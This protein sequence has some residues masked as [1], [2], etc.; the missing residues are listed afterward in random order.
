MFMYFQSCCLYVDSCCFNDNDVLTAVVMNPAI[1]NPV[2][3][4][5]LLS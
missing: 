2:V 1:V 5:I 4:L 3:T